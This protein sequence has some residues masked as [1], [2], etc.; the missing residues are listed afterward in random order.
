M[1]SLPH[2]PERHDVVVVGARCAGAATAMLLARAG[3]DVVLVDRATFPSDT[4]STHAIARSGVVQLRR[5]G[6]LDRVLASGAPPLRDIGFHDADRVV[7]RRLTPRHGVDA[8]VAPR[9]AVLD[10]L[11]V[12]AARA[13]G[14]EVRTGVTVEGVIRTGTGKVS[15]VV[16]RGSHDRLG[17]GRIELAGRLVVGADGLRSRIARAVGA[18]LLRAEAP[19][20]STHYTYMAGDWPQL[21][22]H[23]GERAFGGVFPT[24][25]G[26]ACV[27]VCAPAEMAR[28]LRRTAADVDEAFDALVRAV[29]SLEAR[30]AG[31]R[32]TAPARGAVA[33][34][35]HVRE[36]TGPGWALVGDAAY[37]R[38]P[39]TGHGMSDAYRDADLLAEA[40]DDVLAGG[41][42]AA[43][44][45]RYDR[46]RVALLTP[47][48][49]VACQMI[50]FPG[51]DRFRALQIRLGELIDAEAAILAA[52]PDSLRQAA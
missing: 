37:H 4:L 16:A 40:I 29:P 9:R 14:A 8:L 11:L 22:Y 27:W 50:R 20:G 43:A 47:L 23:L 18:R 6:L 33:L 17:H 44:L 30:L 19:L 26:E 52:R 34:P 7:T 31:R 42:E 13:A 39:V 24:H 25:D 41:D 10:A 2:P 45:C 49:D 5:W 3:H 15:G 21:E 35:N 46:R 48:L 36:G 1:P 38:D 32:C 51:R 28:T 12:D